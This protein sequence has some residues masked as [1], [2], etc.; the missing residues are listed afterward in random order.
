MPVPRPLSFMSFPREIR[1]MIYTEALRPN[2]YLR[3]ATNGKTDGEI[4]P[5]IWETLKELWLTER[6]ETSTAELAWK[7]H[8]SKTIK[9]VRPVVGALVC[10][11]KCV[12]DETIPLLYGRVFVI[13]APHHQAANFLQSI[14]PA[15]RTHIRELVL[16]DTVFPSS[17]LQNALSES[18]NA[19]KIGH[20]IVK[21]P[22]LGRVTIMEN[23]G[24]DTR[25]SSRS[26]YAEDSDDDDYDENRLRSRLLRIR[27]EDNDRPKID[28][29]ARATC[30][31]TLCAA[32]MKGELKELRFR[33]R[34]NY[35]RT[36]DFDT[37][38]CVREVTQPPNKMDH[39]FI[40]RLCVSENYGPDLIER[41]SFYKDISGRRENML[42]SGLAQ[43]STFGIYYRVQDRTPYFP[44]H[45]DSIVLKNDR[46]PMRVSLDVLRRAEYDKQSKI[47]V[48]TTRGRVRQQHPARERNPASKTDDTVLCITWDPKLMTE[49]LPKLG[50]I[51]CSK[52]RRKSDSEVYN[53][54]DYKPER[55]PHLRRGSVEVK[56]A[57]E[58]APDFRS[59]KP[60]L[61]GSWARSILPSKPQRLAATFKW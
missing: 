8:D 31:D 18:C 43:L 28:N 1:D 21:E 26:E 5:T 61:G 11:S 13:D 2:E 19:H 29:I 39:E 55:S 46:F 42:Y 58:S 17:I 54:C 10:V 22:C 50:P 3:L 57:A 56:T 49:N 24:F 20:A 6:F 16:L 45:R 52:K 38:A 44:V 30:I 25:L 27:K 15:V 36:R 34:G 60:S 9:A 53:R 4:R 32:L 33:L 37:F 12:H 35:S 48:M 40:T 59:T 23:R 41:G 51:T 47:P 14:N 7:M